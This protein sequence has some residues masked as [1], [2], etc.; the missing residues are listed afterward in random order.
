MNEKPIIEYGYVRDFINI[1][2]ETEPQ[3]TKQ[4]EKNKYLL[5]TSITIWINNCKRSL[6]EIK[7]L[8]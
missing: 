4:G 1:W 8:E 2:C 6:L 3:D 7:L 5:R